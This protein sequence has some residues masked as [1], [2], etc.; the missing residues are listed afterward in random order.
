M[1]R[2]G[3]HCFQQIFSKATQ[4]GRRIKG[5]YFIS[6]CVLAIWFGHAKVA[7]FIKNIT[8]SIKTYLPNI[9]TTLTDHGP[10]MDA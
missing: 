4:C 5:L 1:Y 3:Q 2:R 10:N 7:R 6:G 9:F 8:S